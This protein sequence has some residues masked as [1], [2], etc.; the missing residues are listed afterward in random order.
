MD[1]HYVLCLTNIFIAFL[2]LFCF[3]QWRENLRTF[4]YANQ[5]AEHDIRILHGLAKN[6]MSVF[7]IWLNDRSFECLFIHLF[8]PFSTMESWSCSLINCLVHQHS[9]LINTPEN[10]QIY[11]DDLN[12]MEWNSFA[13]NTSTQLLKLRFANPPIDSKSRFWQQYMKNL[14]NCC[15]SMSSSFQFVF[16]AAS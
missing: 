7:Q 2:I 4:E 5:Q 9:Y 14:Y 8:L 15:S 11:F 10:L 16:N 3:C 12:C 13:K 1:I 6:P